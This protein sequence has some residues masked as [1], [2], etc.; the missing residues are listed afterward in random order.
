M[1]SDEQEVSYRGRKTSRAG[2]EQRRK[3]ILE[4]ALRIVIRDGVRGVRHR[5]VAKE[6]D[7]PLSATTYY[8]KDISDLIADTFILFAENAMAQVIDPFDGR[9]ANYLS[10]CDLENI[11]SKEVQVVVMAGVVRLTAEHICEELE[12][13]PGHIMAEQAFLHEATRD[14]TLRPLALKYRYNLEKGLRQMATL[15]GSKSVELDA[16]LLLTAILHVEYEGLLDPAGVDVETINKTLFHL[17]S[18]LMAVSS[19]E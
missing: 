11:A 8:F 19:A 6:A 14:A 13:K 3:S 15:F 18:S 4:A 2:S 16:K 9:I 10:Q 1:F 12:D 7:V 5:A 17:F